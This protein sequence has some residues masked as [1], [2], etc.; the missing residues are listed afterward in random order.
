MLGKFKTRSTK[1]WKTTRNKHALGCGL[2][3]TNLDQLCLSNF[4]YFSSSLSDMVLCQ[5]D[6]KCTLWQCKVQK[7]I[8]FY[9]FCTL[10]G[11]TRETHTR[12]GHYQTLYL[13]IY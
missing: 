8:V 10:K 2:V 5:G 13:Q 9:D 7:H 6:V 12:N 11:P 3:K 1:H 4:S